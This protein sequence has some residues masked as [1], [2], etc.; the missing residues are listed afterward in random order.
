MTSLLRLLSFSSSDARINLVSYDKPLTC[1]FHLVF[2]LTQI[3]WQRNYCK[4]W[5]IFL[6][7]IY[8]LEHLE[9]VNPWQLSVP[10]MIIGLVAFSWFGLGRLFTYPD[11]QMVTGFSVVFSLEFVFY[12]KLLVLFHP[13][14]VSLYVSCVLNFISG[15]LP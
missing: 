9:K 12:T 10:F 3:I 4:I 5:K 2:A 14:V 8:F 11:V 6:I 7:K 13:D 1:L 15:E